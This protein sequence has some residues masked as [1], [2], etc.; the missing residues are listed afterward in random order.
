MRFKYKKGISLTEVMVSVTL[1]AILSY[2]A[3]PIYKGHRANT[4]RALFKTD[5]SSLHKGWQAF[6][7]KDRNYCYNGTS[8][9]SA[10]FVSVGLKSLLISKNYGITSGQKPNFIGFG[11]IASTTCRAGNGND[12]PEVVAKFDESTDSNNL[13]AVGIGSNASGSATGDEN[14]TLESSSYTLGV[15]GRVGG[16]FEGYYIKDE[17]SLGQ[18]ESMPTNPTTPDGNTGC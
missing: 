3:L 1:I 15:F 10:N 4:Q 18:K 2:I 9:V 5:L 12:T 6:G 7:I 14:C 8:G 11:R 17:G 13:K 16:E